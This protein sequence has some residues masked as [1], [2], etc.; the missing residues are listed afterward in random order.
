MGSI[1]GRKAMDDKKKPTNQPKPELL[2]PAD[3]D[4]KGG[5]SAAQLARKASKQSR[6]HADLQTLCSL[7]LE[8]D[9]LDVS[10]FKR[11]TLRE[12][13][14]V[15]A[16]TSTC[17]GNPRQAKRVA[18]Y[19]DTTMSSRILEK[20]HIQ[21]AI[22][23][24]FRC[25]GVSQGELMASLVSQMRVTQEDFWSVDD[26]GRIDYNLKEA[27]Q[28]GRFKNIKRLKLKRIWKPHPNPLEGGE[29][30]YEEVDLE[31]HSPDAARK[32]LLDLMRFTG[33]QRRE[34]SFTE[35]KESTNQA[36][37][38]V[39][40]LTP[41]LLKAIQGAMDE[42]GCVDVGKLNPEQLIAYTEA[43]TRGI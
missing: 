21:A 40:K 24:V 35:T 13:A 20:P 3:M 5:P 43:V 2:P 23:E 25:A 37:I 15:T 1:N 28:K 16:L 29:V 17:W 22:R 34:L 4:H 19:S 32:Q 38:D 12:E 41:D 14:F 39:R 26:D 18:G 42:T 10:Y 31:L 27:Y 36:T 8:S 9:G 33:S 30:L 11:L 6:D 7:A